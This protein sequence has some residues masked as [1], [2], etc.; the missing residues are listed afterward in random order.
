MVESSH[1]GGEVDEAMQGEE[2]CWDHLSR[3]GE[4]ANERQGFRLSNRPLAHPRFGERG[5]ILQLGRG[6][7]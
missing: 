6:Q 3:K 2:A 1:C 7:L 4:L 5:D